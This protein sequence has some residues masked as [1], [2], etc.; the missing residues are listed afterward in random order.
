MPP[1]PFN[2]T[3]VVIGAWNPA[4]LSPN[5]VTR[6]LF[7]LPADT[8]VELQIAVDRPGLF[9]VSHDGIIVAPTTTR[10]E[11]TS[12]VANTEG[13]SRACVLCQRALRSL[14]ET[15]VTAVGINVR[16]RFAEI[17]NNVLDMVRAPLDEALSDAGH[18]VQATAAN[19]SVTLAPGVIKMQISTDDSGGGRF[20]FNFHKESTV[21]A[22]LIA[23][24][25]RVDEFINISDEL[26]AVAGVTDVRREIHA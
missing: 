4:I 18:L 15:P 23:W 13:L 1:E 21:P 9:R 12:S 10:L 11:V 24:L 17:P 3:A 16:Y 7:E 26:A 8:P 5:G 20:E 22:E 2:W 25:E 14:P 6:R 19:R